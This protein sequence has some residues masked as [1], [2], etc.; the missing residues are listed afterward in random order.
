MTCEATPLSFLA[1][2]IDYP[3]ILECIITWLELH[4][5]IIY[6]IERQLPLHSLTI[7]DPLEYLPYLLVEQCAYSHFAV[8]PLVC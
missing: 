4:I 5:Q 1:N 2:S 6:L 8:P 3:Y 7:C